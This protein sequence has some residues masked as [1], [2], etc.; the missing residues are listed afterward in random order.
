MWGLS[1]VTR[2]GTHAPAVEVQS[3]NHWTARE[4]PPRDLLES[5]SVMSLE[6]VGGKKTLKKT[7][8]MDIFKHIYRE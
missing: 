1:S 7:F 3:L 4:V 5:F 8:I 6:M 2:D